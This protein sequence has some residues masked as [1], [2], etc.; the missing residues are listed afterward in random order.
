MILIT[1]LVN[2]LKLVEIELRIVDQVRFK[3]DI[4]Y[5]T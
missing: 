3:E 5:K 4:M 2:V 1:Q